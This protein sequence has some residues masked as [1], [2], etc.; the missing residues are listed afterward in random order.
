MLIFTDA[1]PEPGM[2]PGNCTEFSGMNC[3][4]YLDYTRVRLINFMNAY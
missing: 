2:N 4:V 3:Y 1:K